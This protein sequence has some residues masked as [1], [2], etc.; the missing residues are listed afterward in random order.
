MTAVVVLLIDCSLS[1][2]AWTGR[3]E[4]RP[5]A[6]CKAGVDRFC[7]RIGSLVACLYGRSQHLW[8]ASAQK[9]LMAKLKTHPAWWAIYSGASAVSGLAGSI[10]L[11]K[12]VSIANICT[13]K[14]S[15]GKLQQCRTSPAVQQLLRGSIQLAA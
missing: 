8:P 13:V 1:H 11:R 9:K 12:N 7:Q 10:S 4:S 15:Y 2:R 6:A 3:R 5:A 14:Q